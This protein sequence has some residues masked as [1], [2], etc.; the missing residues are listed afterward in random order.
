[1]PHDIAHASLQP[2]GTRP[3]HNMCVYIYMYMHAHACVTGSKH[4]H[5]PCFIRTHRSRCTYMCY[6]HVL[7]SC[8]PF[9][10]SQDR[11]PASVSCLFSQYC[12][13]SRP[14]LASSLY[15]SKIIVMTL[16]IISGRREGRA[17][18]GLLTAA[19]SV[20]FVMILLTCYT[21]TYIIMSTNHNAALDKQ[22]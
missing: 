17:S 20:P 16:C 7:H 22:V 5:K 19:N 14:H 18:G 9:P 3:D 4:M 8:A 21:H 15:Y 11:V 2:T 13:H 1:M 6:T 10:W 12:R